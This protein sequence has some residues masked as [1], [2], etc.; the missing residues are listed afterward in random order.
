MNI[1]RHIPWFKRS[2]ALPRGTVA[3]EQLMKGNPLWAANP[4]R[5]TLA[6]TAWD[7]GNIAEMARIV[8]AYEL[9][10]DTA[11]IGVKK[12]D[13]SVARCEHSVLIEEGA[14]KDPRAQL[15]KDILEKFWASIRVTS[16]FNRAEKGGIRLLKKQMMSAQS[17]GWSCHNIVWDT[18]DPA[19]IRAT[20][21]HIPMWHFENIT[22]ELRFK[23]LATDYYGVP[24]ADGEWLVNT[25]D[26][27]GPAVALACCAKRLSLQ[28]W[29]LF[30]ERAATPGLLGKTNAAPGTDAWQKMTEMLLRWGRE[31]KGIVDKDSDITTVSMNTGEPPMPRLVER[32]DRAI[33][34]LYRGADL[35]TLSKGEGMGASLQGDESDMLEAD[36]CATLAESLHEQVDRYVI[37]YMTG[38]DT[39]LAY[40]W[41]EPVSKPNIDNE[42]KIDTHLMQSGIKLSKRDML[43]RYGRT[44]ADPS[45]PEDAVEFQ[46]PSNGLEMGFNAPLND[47][48]RLPNAATPFKTHQTAFKN[49]R[50]DSGGQRGGFQSA[51]SEVPSRASGG[52]SQK[53]LEAVARDT[54]PAAQVVKRFMELI[55]SGAT[56]DAIRGQAAAIMRELPSL[57]PD[58]P[59]LATVIRDAITEAYVNASLDALAAAGSAATAPSIPSP[60]TITNQ[61]S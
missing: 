42:I 58:D 2:A 28:D 57:L 61:I 16:A 48:R 24:M 36:D 40:I 45:E 35:S 17:I 27:I 19:N 30:S 20:F 46:Q 39:P 6:V 32:M 55:E 21:I 59:A 38:D 31:W 5:L 51:R 10:D 23:Q 41:I 60:S 26:A 8:S 34:A 7:A 13:A 1:F 52:D 4:D 33:A 47:P 56:E 53:L 15:H 50:S 12:R 43:Q 9:H 25:G 22:G 18:S 3:M 14:E 54:E 29:M 11:K 37:R 44:E 49:A